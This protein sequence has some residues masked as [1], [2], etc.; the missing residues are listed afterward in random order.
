MLD[1]LSRL[2]IAYAHLAVVSPV[3][4][5]GGFFDLLRTTAGWQ[6][7]G[8]AGWR[9]EWRDGKHF[10]T[11]EGG[12]AVQPDPAYGVEAI[13]GK[14]RLDHLH[15]RAT[16]CSRQQRAHLP[17]ARRAGAEEYEREEFHFDYSDYRSCGA[18]LVQLHRG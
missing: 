7:S 9:T 13:A 8:G 16:H 6:S 10:C 14:W 12:G 2:E 4:S 1:L 18:H 5:G 15:E 17:G 3:H 11:A